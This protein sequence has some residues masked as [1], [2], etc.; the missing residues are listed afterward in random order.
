MKIMIRLKVLG[1]GFCGKT[2]ANKV[3]ETI[4]LLW[5]TIAQS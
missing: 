5:P 1:K 3:A 2:L 4:E